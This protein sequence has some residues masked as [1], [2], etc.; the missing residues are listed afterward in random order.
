VLVACPKPEEV[1]TEAVLKKLPFGIKT[2]EVR[3][4]GMV[5]PHTYAPQLGDKS[6]ETF[7]ANAAVTVSI[8]TA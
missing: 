5:S 6:A 1:D 2:I 4:G 7:V 8:D 3:E